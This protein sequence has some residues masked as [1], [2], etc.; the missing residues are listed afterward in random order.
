MFNLIVLLLMTN[1]CR[2]IQVG[3]FE[4]NNLMRNEKIQIFLLLLI[5]LL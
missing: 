2:G 4:A 1:F 5:V 3:S